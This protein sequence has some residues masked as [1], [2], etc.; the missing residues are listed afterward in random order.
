MGNTGEVLLVSLAAP[1][2]EEVFEG[3]LHGTL[4]SAGTPLLDVVAYAG[5]T[6]NEVVVFGADEY[7]AD[8]FDGC[9]VIIRYVS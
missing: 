1:L 4:T 2:P 7:S 5:P 9:S 8:M 3:F 6:V